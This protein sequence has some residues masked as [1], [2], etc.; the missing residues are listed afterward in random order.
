M[1]DV[2]RD[3]TNAHPWGTARLF[4]RLMEE[5]ERADAKHGRFDG[6]SQLGKSRLALACL[7]RRGSRGRTGMAR[8]A[9]V[10]NMGRDAQRGLAGRRRCHP[11]VEGRAVKWEYRLA[12]GLALLIGVPLLI[13][14][15]IGWA[16]T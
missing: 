3:K 16:L 7:G 12:L 2:M 11:S 6:A 10:L 4:F 9:P 5:V 13:G 1:S 8:R 14:F 15:L